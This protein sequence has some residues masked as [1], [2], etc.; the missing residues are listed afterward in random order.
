MKRRDFFLM[1]STGVA[2]G[3]GAVATAGPAFGPAPP[4]QE[5][6]R[7]M[8]AERFGIRGDGRSDDTDAL[9]AALD[10]LANDR[11]VGILTLPPGDYVVTRPLRL[12]LKKK[13]YGGIWGISAYGARIRSQ[14]DDGRDVLAI[15]STTVA[16]FMLIEGL[17]IRGSG[18]DG[19][20]LSVHCDGNRHY[21]YNAAMRDVVVENCGRDG[22]RMI[23]NIFESQIINSYFRDN[24]ANGVTMGHG[25]AG[26]VLSAIHAFGCV[27]GGNGSHGIALI[28]KSNDVSFSGCYFLLN[29]K[30]GLLASNGVV[31][32]AHCGFENNHEA[33][34]DF[35]SGGAGMHV[36]VFATLVGCTA[37]SIFKQQRLVSGYITNHFVMMG[38]TGDGGGKAKKAGLARL[39]GNGKGEVTVIGSRG[40]IENGG[41]IALTEIGQP[42]IG[43]RFGSAWDSENLVRLGDYALWVDDDGEL[44]M[45][46]GNPSSDK[47][48]RRISDARQ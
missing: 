1:S 41:G 6:A 34:D 33:A 39:K 44:R 13:R 14:I 40:R 29:G 2:L 5:P 11:E 22:C 46:S 37:Y 47:D 36:N 15:D 42:G 32:L 25:K 26:G 43:A 30:Y 12:D 27:F 45:K 7:G 19:N 28:R 8:S 4:P 31:L 21:I 38:C 17:T 24:G 20:G 48:G 23:G 3:A 16:R 9:Q 10:A 35:E 18:K